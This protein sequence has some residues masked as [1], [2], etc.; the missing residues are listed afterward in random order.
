[1]DVYELIIQKGTLG[2]L[3]YANQIENKNYRLASQ[4]DEAVVNFYRNEEMVRI[5]QGEFGYFSPRGQNIKQPDKILE[6]REQRDKQYGYYKVP[7]RGTPDP[8]GY[9]RSPA[10]ED[11]LNNLKNN[12]YQVPKY[13]EAKSAIN[14]ARDERL[15][16]AFE[17][18]LKAGEIN[19]ATDLF[20]NSNP[21]LTNLSTP[22]MRQRFL[23]SASKILKFPSPEYDKFIKNVAGIMSQE[24]ASKFIPGI[25]KSPVKNLLNLGV[26]IHPAI[27]SAPGFY[28]LSP[29]ITKELMGK[30]FDEAKYILE[31]KTVG[32]QFLHDFKQYIAQRGPGYFSEKYLQF[33]PRAKEKIVNQGILKLVEKFPQIEGALA[34]F[35]G[36]KIVFG[37]IIG[38]IILAM[39]AINLWHDV[40]VY[41]WD[42]KNICQL[43]SVIIGSGAIGTAVATGGAGTPLAALLSVLWLVASIGCGVAQH[44]KPI[45]GKS[46]PQLQENT[47]QIT[48]NNIKNLIGKVKMSD[49][50]TDDQ[51]RARE[52][53]NDWKNNK[54][55][56]KRNF[57]EQ[58]KG[59]L[60]K[61]PVSVLA[62]LES[63]LRDG[64]FFF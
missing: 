13:F 41:R 58:A 18:A 19:K 9:L 15:F 64:S 60:F 33:A 42:S 50:S 40:D 54:Q 27:K 23:D 20:K 55:A 32:T 25:L 47:D 2:A 62:G 52:I 57:Y 61:K 21:L 63:Y 37:K 1:M 28:T 8:D 10:S 11:P 48:D 16:K 31:Q 35:G 38:P 51:N 14:L 3:K 56:M 49:L 4:I 46:T 5:A 45:P 7:P 44:D 29:D 59:G 26:A 43:V 36:A 24:S 34:K 30:S 17:S 22:P 6:Q 12:L 53:F 39:D